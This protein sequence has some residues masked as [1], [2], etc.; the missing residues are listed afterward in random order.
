M[1]ESSKYSLSRTDLVKVGKGM[2]V[3]IGGVVSAAL[4][5]AVADQIS[6]LPTQIDF[7]VYQGLAVVVC[8]TLV[9]GIRKW[10]TDNSPKEGQK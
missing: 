1:S 9:N 5:L 8:S 6:A 4:A 3:S 7:G 2:L 10:I